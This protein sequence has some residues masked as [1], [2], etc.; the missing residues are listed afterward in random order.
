MQTTKLCTEISALRYTL[1]FV[2][3]VDGT[4]YVKMYYILP[5]SLST[6]KRDSVEKIKPHKIVKVMK[7][8]MI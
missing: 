1:V 6:T 2:K 4:Y 5:T 3:Y 8:L 7:V